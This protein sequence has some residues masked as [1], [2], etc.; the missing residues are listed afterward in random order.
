MRLKSLFKNKLLNILSL[1][2][3]LVLVRLVTGFISVKAMALLIGPGG[4]A[5]MG[6][7]RSFLTAAQSL[8]SLGIRDGIVRFVSEKKHEENALK[9]V[10]SSALLI[11]LVLSLLVSCCI[12]LG[13]DRL[14]A[15]LFP[16]GSYASVFK[17]TAFLLPLS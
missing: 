14:N 2:A 3:L 8:A 10:F 1:N 4:I 6:N 7:F 5:L 15:Y 13:S 16:G 12:F 11:V 9:K 17:I